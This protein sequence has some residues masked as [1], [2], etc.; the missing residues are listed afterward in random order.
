MNT[1]KRFHKGFTLIELLIVIGILAVLATVTVL[2]LNP[3][4]LFMQ[5]RDSQRVSDLNTI[6]DAISLYVAVVASPD[7]D[8]NSVTFTCGTNF[9]AS[10]A[11]ASSS[12]A[13][14]TLPAASHTGILTVDGTG[15]VPVQFTSIQ[16]VVGA[17]PISALPRD[18]TNSGTTAPTGLY[19]EYSC[20]NT[21][22]TFELNANLE[23]NRYTTGTENK[24]NSDGGDNIIYY[25]LGTDAG[26]NL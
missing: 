24:E 20:D 9:G 3:A 5:A 12:M 2:V 15:W 18:P 10:L 4:Q 6:R 19:Y 25:E 1:F 22:D 13:A 11:A 26:L 7:M 23:S 8:G 14:V 17:T 21:N 16:S